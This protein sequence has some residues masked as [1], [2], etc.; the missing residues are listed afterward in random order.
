MWFALMVIGIWGFTTLGAYI[1]KEPGI[2]ALAAFATVVLGTGYLIYKIWK[3]AC[4]LEDK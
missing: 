2:Y 3:L 1:T 4:K